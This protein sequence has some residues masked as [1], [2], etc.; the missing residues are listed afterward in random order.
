MGDSEVTRGLRHQPGGSVNGLGVGGCGNSLRWGFCVC[1]CVRLC[2]RRGFPG[3][4]PAKP[5]TSQSVSAT[6]EDVR[7]ATGRAWGVG[8]GSQEKGKGEERGSEVEGSDPECESR[9]GI[10]VAGSAI[11]RAELDQED[12]SQRLT[13]HCLINKVRKQMLIG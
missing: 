8:E 13:C 6:T 11:A 5:G 12:V 10:C 4:D 3:R 2:F 1:V 7:G 9:A